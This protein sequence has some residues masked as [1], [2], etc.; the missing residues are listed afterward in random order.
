MR[1]FFVW[2]VAL[3]TQEL[4]AVRQ[5]AAGSLSLAGRL[6]GVAPL[7][8]VL[9]SADGALRMVTFERGWAAYDGSGSG[10]LVAVCAAPLP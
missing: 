1:D 10:T 6:Q 8:A 7:V 2:D 5:L 9:R 4:A 3:T